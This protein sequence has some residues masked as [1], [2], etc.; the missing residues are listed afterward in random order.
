[1]PRALAGGV[2]TIQVL[3]GSAN[4]IGGRSFTAKLTRGT[5]A[6]AMRFL[7]APQGLKMAC[8]EN[9]K[10]VYGEQRRLP[11]TRMGN[12]AVVRKAFADAW[13]YRRRVQKYERDLALWKEKQ[14]KE[15]QGKEEQARPTSSSSPSSPFETAPKDT[16]ELGADPEAKV[17]APDDP[18]EPPTRDPALETLKD[19]L[20]GKILVHNHC[21]RADEMSLMLD[22]AQQYGFRIRSFHHALEAYK[23]ADRLAREGV[24]VSTWADWWGFKMEAYDGVPENAALVAAAGGRAIIHSDSESEIRHLN[25]EAGKALAAGRRLGLKIDDDA[26]LRWLTANP[27]WALGIDDRV[28]TLEPGKMADVVVWDRHPFSVY[29]LAQRV[30][31]DGALAFDRRAARA[32]TDFELENGAQAV[33]GER[34]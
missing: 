15:K 1:L 12:L 28:G 34:R 2:T 29:A 7:G 16:A 17:A 27:A 5:S 20:D 31:V 19:V 4:L 6:R 3:P 11:S 33:Q 26:A 13:D 9:P 25:Q 8:G 32:T 30:Y 18:P 22:L 23:I 21:Y 10:R 14:R 24:A